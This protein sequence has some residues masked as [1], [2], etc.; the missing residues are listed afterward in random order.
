[1]L[2]IWISTAIL[3]RRLRDDVSEGVLQPTTMHWSRGQP[4]QLSCRDAASL[5]GEHLVMMVVWG[6]Q[7]SWGR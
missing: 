2:V 7:G 5:S 6:E 4:F 1:M 3:H